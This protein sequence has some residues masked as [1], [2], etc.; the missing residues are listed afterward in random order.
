[1]PVGVRAAVGI[2]WNAHILSGGRIATVGV[3]P[4][5]QHV[6]QLGARGRL[7]LPAPVRR[8]L[9]IDEGD[10]VVITVEDDG[11]LRV[12]SLKRKIRRFQGMFK[13]LKKG[14]EWSQELIEQRRAE[15]EEEP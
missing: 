10:R 6:V 7:V 14:G 2:C 4:K 13:G 3:T 5:Q 8:R 15:T 12:A 9:G 11:S 1:V